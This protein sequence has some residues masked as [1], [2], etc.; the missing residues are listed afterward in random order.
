M[1]TSFRWATKVCALALLLVMWMP[2][3]GHAQEVDADRDRANRYDDAWK[4]GPAGWV[5]H[6]RAVHRAAS[7]KT[8]GFVLHL[9]DSITFSKSYGLLAASYRGSHAGDAS[10]IAWSTGG[11]SF[12]DA[13]PVNKNGWRLTNVVHPEGGRS[14]TAS[15]GITTEQWLKGGSHGMAAGPRDRAPLDTLLE[16]RSTAPYAPPDRFVAVVEDAQVA[17][18]MLGTNDIGHSAADV[19]GIAGRLK[20]IVAKLEAK[21]IMVVLSTIPPCR[22]CERVEALNAEITALART[23]AL[24]LIDYHAEIL[25]RRPGGTWDGTLISRD[26]VHPSGGPYQDPDAMGGQP[27]SDSG[28]LLRGFLSVQKLSELRRFVLDGEEPGAD[29]DSTDPGKAVPGAC[30]GR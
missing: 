19:K 4:R 3:L 9:G 5:A 2:A 13:S 15:T 27:L 29:L 22:E 1:P 14:Y 18:V 12:T 23:M 8:E 6:L 26:G 28:Y 21:A 10:T 7:G 20:Q 11:G 17:I 24:P 16:N 30:W 25:R